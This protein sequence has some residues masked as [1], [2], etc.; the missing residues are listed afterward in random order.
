MV[1]ADS[2]RES[3]S[4]SPTRF[5]RCWLSS[6]MVSTISRWSLFMGPASSLRIMSAPMKMEV[7]GVLNS[8]E[9]V[10]MKSPRAR[11][12]SFSSVT[13]WSRTMKPVVTP[14]ASRMGVM[15]TW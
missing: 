2:M 3:S 10:A 15:A 4:S 5:S 1:L 13:L 9:M 6:Q 11:S 7:S 8:W 14:S 12:S